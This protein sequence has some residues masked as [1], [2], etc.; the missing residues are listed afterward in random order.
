VLSE[1]EGRR[2]DNSTETSID[3]ARSIYTHRI[4]YSSVVMCTHVISRNQDSLPVQNLCAV[5]HLAVM[6][7]YVPNRCRRHINST[8][9]WSTCV[10]IP[11]RSSSQGVDQAAV[12]Q[13][14]GD[15]HAYTTSMQYQWTNHVAY[16]IHTQGG[17][18][19]DQHTGHRKR[20]RLFCF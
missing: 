7:A 12:E 10:C 8:K 18:G 20:V 15:M 17:E 1:R 19:E 3:H 11:A 6:L 4:V 2:G 14:A 5:P 13:L 16:R 9:L